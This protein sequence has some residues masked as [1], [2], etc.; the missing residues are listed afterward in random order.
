MEPASTPGFFVKFLEALKDL[1]L[2]LLAAIT[3]LLCIFLV[4]AAFSDLVSKETWGWIR[5]G[6]VGFGVL[7]AFRAA[8]ALVHRFAPSPTKQPKAFHLTPID[9]ESDWYAAKQADGSLSLQ[10]NANLTVKNLLPNA[11]L[12]LVTVMLVRPKILR[13]IMVREVAVEMP[14]QG[15][16]SARHGAYVPGGAF[17][18]VNIV[19]LGLID[20]K[21]PNAPLSV[22][23]EVVDASGNHQRVKMTLRCSAPARLPAT[24]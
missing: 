17:R 11:T 8:D 15:F 3:T 1:P 12:Y 13:T 9:Q 7:T 2:W 10:L 16:S 19:I 22:V 23:F 4:F 21:P 6:A 14:G 5:V 20:E 18:R 24:L